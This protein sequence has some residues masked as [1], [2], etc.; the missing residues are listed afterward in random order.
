MCKLHS[1]GWGN[2][3]PHSHRHVRKPFQSDRGHNAKETI[4]A[5]CWC[6][7]QKESVCVRESG[8]GAQAKFKKFIKLPLPHS[9]LERHSGK[10]WETTPDGPSDPAKIVSMGLGLH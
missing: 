8:W 7:A 1:T 9:Q 10:V 5:F 3:V 6:T 4:D 2:I